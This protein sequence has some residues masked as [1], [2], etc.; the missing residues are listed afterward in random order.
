MGLVGFEDRL[1][2]ESA[3]CAAHQQGSLARVAVFEVVPRSAPV[4]SLVRNGARAPLCLHRVPGFIALFSE[5]GPTQTG[6]VSLVVCPEVLKRNR[7][8]GS[9]KF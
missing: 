5:L 3:A 9:S 2:V 8:D 1:C 6:I 7:N 4:G